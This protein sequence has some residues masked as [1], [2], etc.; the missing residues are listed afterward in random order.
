LMMVS[1]DAPPVV[2]ICELVIDMAA[3]L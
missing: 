2:L 3:K 1:L